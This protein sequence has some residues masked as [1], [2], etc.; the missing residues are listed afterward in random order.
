MSSSIPC[1]L[2]TAAVQALGCLSI[3]QAD[4]FPQLEDATHI[5]RVPG[6]GK[7][8][9][10]LLLAPYRNWATTVPGTGFQERVAMQKEPAAS[11]EVPWTPRAAVLHWQQLRHDWVELLTGLGVIWPGLR[12]YSP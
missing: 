9:S 7:G 11:L 12:Y 8:P 10:T 1:A 4:V 3:P 5:G 2:F 6:V